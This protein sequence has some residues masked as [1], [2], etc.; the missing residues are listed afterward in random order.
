[1]RNVAGLIEAS[2]T[3]TV[4]S[5]EKLAIT[6]PTN[7]YSTEDI[8]DALDEGKHDSVFDAHLRKLLKGIV[9][10]LHGPF[11]AFKAAH[12]ENQA[13]SAMDVWLKALSTGVAPFASELIGLPIT[14]SKQELFVAEQVEA[15][16]R[17]ALNSK[18]AL[19]RAAY[20]QLSALYEEA[21]KNLKASDF[22]G[23]QAEMD[24]IFA[25][26]QNADGTSDHLARFAALGL[27]NKQFNKLLKTATDR[28]PKQKAKGI[29]EWL[30]SIFES[31]L[32]FFSNK[33][34]HTYAGQNADE[35]LTVL[36]EQLVDIEAK[37]VDMF[38]S[39]ANR[40][41]LLAP[42]EAV[43]KTLADGLMDKVGKIAK[44]RYVSTHKNSFVRAGGTLVEMIVDNQVDAFTEAL[45]DA[46]D[47]QYKGKQGMVANAF[48]YALGASQRLQELL[49]DAKAHEGTRKNLII[50]TAATA[51]STFKN[52]GQYLTGTDKKAIDLN[53]S[54]T[55]VV[56]RTGMHHLL[57][58][59]TTDQLGDMVN[60]KAVLNKEI[61]V[62]EALLNQFG[63]FKYYFIQQANVL[64]YHKAQGTVRGDY[65]MMNAHN[66]VQMYGTAYEG[67]LSAADMKMAEEVVAR[68][69]AMYAID[70]TKADH[71][72]L[73]GEVFNTENSRTDGNGVLFTL[74]NMKRLEQ[75][76]KD[77]N[78]DGKTVLMQHGYTPEVTDPY[79][80]L[81][82]ATFSEGED[83]VD[84][85]YKRLYP[86]PKDP[87]DPDTETKYLY[88]LIGAG[89]APYLSAAVST[90]GL[91]A[92]GSPKH[93]GF[94]NPYT[95]SGLT[96]A[97]T[98][99][100][101]N[102]QKAAAVAKLFK[103]SARADLRN[104]G[105]TYLAP[106][107]NENGEVANWRYMMEENA[108]D[109]LLTRDNRFE[110]LM[111]VLAGSIFDKESSREQNKIVLNALKEQYDL[112]KATKQ[113]SYVLIGPKSADAEHRATWDLLP[114]S[115]KDEARR[116]FGK[117]GI[118]VRGDEKNIVFG[119]RK[120][121]LAEMFKK[122]PDARIQGEKLFVGLVEW[123]LT[124]YAISRGKTRDE[125]EKYAKRSAVYVARSERAW[126]EVVQATKDILVVKT[127]LVMVG[128]IYSNFTLLALA[129]VSF[130]DMAVNSL[131]ALKGATAYH[132]DMAE[133]DRNKALLNSGYTQGNEVEIKR[134]IAK[135]EDALAR[136]PVKSMIDAGLMPTI[137]EDLA[138]DED[139]YSYKSQLMKKI[140]K[141]TSKLNPKIVSA[142]RTVFM[143]HDTKMY[144]GL[145]RMTQLSDFVARY[146]MY[147]HLTNRKTDPLSHT[148]A[149]QEAS[150]SFVNYDIPMPKEI[151]FTD[152]M[153]FTIF[154]KYYL[155]I[156][157]VLLRHAKNN[158][159]RILMGTLIGNFMDLGP[160]ILESSVFHKFGNNPF[161]LGALNFPSKVDDIATINTALAMLR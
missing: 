150:D 134:T 76:S 65:M 97:V 136:N 90:T 85:G 155:S 71:L 47:R 63:K 84:Q 144:Q 138:V 45:H 73:A 133:L 119:Y 94:M 113:V 23:G 139:I 17:A 120:Y 80:E 86:L 1:M 14:M 60:D 141:Q 13:G 36:V 66:I 32:E 137:V 42:V 67:R 40:R 19:V 160:S 82:S 156:Q 56:V 149:V 125:A 112:E 87:A 79:V 159:A 81:V 142:G 157:R 70:Y 128:N 93:N 72:A 140:D 59:Y 55:R 102:T 127:G 15:T 88:Q 152:D 2:K 158:P 123:V 122:D 96:N 89:M 106:V 38:K 74:K 114:D 43:V 5:N 54:I 50:N 35:K 34:T 83:L 91:N 124:Q 20:K 151:Q 105:R 33:I 99:A 51:L 146:T 30:Q 16:V 57:G 29:N 21:R 61:D 52:A 18:E 98:H 130:K 37:R 27:A 101:I 49:R 107:L 116:V 46:H 126:Q 145:S 3:Q 44:S 75:E 121:S 111:G 26:K 28:N 154:T 110:K 10:N 12:M 131:V 11:D 95:Q 109:T 100:T 108:R 148:D 8:H 68:L 147:Q 48:N 132:S 4:S 62:Q 135:L 7:T 24:A 22:A 161:G 77:R 41:D 39:L 31:I 53:A 6:V 58:T 117:D 9:T 64:G 143:T 78:F 92:K 153:G 118:W 69:I 104:E 129:G 115:M 25:I 103:K